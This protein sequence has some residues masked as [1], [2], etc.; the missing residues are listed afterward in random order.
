VT[1]WIT[2]KLNPQQMDPT[3]QQIFSLMPWVM[4]FILSPFAA[5]LLLNWVT[6]KIL[7]S[8]QQWWMYKRFGLHFSDT[9]QVQS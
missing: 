3:Q 1:Q 5:G 6:N 4:M 8:E 9:H 7:T 2:F